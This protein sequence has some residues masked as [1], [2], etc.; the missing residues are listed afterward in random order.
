MKARTIWAPLQPSA[1]AAARNARFS[2]GSTLTE[3]L[4]IFFVISAIPTGQKTRMSI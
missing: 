4:E 3:M 2:S 1:R